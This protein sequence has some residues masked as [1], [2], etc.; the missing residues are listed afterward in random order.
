V[1]YPDLPNPQAM[2]DIRYFRQ[3][4][5]PFFQFA[6]V[7]EVVN[8]VARSVYGMTQTGIEYDCNL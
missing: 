4:P 1:D 3:N 8:I 5:K 6:K 2:F 7:C